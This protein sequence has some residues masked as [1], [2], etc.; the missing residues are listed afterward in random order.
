MVALFFLFTGLLLFYVMRKST[1]EVAS[2]TR[3]NRRG[4]AIIS[5]ALMQDNK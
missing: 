3:R 5:R 2:I 4:Q 1:K